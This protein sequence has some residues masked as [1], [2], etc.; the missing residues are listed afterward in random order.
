M[1]WAREATGWKVVSGVAP[2]AV[3]DAVEEALHR[4]GQWDSMRYV[5]TDEVA[6][7]RSA[8]LGEVD[9]EVRLGLKDGASVRTIR[10]RFGAVVG[11]S[12]IVLAWFDDD[13]LAL[14]LE[15]PEALHQ[16]LVQ[17]IGLP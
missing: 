10:L 16:A 17:F 11:A 3:P 7:A 2:G 14:R 5:V 13:P 15:M 8:R 4:L 12:R 1:G 6:V 9:H